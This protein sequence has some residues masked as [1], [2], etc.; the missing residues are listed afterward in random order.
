VI[1]GLLAVT[2]GAFVTV[3]M[4]QNRE[5]G[6]SGQL[7]ES[8]V[9]VVGDGVVLRSE[10][11]MRTD[12][13]IR[14]LLADQ[15]ELPPEQRSP[16][17]P[18][19]VI[20]DQVLDQLILKQI[21]MQRAERVGIVIGDDILNQALSQ[22]AAN[23]GVT[24]ENL[25][26][27]LEA[28]GLDY[29]IYRQDQRD[30]L[31]LSQLEQRDVLSRIE[32]SPRELEQ[33]LARREATETD[34]FDYNIS[35]ILIGISGS[36]QADELRAAQERVEE[37][38]ARLEAG[39][40][41]AQLAVEYSEGPTALEGGSLGWRKG[42]QLPTLFAD[43]VTE[44]QPGEISETIQSGSGFHIVRLNDMR[45]AER[46]MVDQVRARHIL[47]IPNEILDRDATLQKLI[48]IR[49]QILAGDDFGTLAI[50]QSEDTVSGSDGGDL[51]WAE[52][53]AYVPEFTEVLERLP[54]GELSEPVETRFGWHL[55]EVLDRRSYDSTDELKARSCQQQLQMSK[56]EEERLVW[57][58]QLRDGA[59]IEKKL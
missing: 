20:Q 44:M 24:L 41:F 45:G 47:L 8:I 7:I 58:Q 57:I 23:V 43:L 22:V 19:A 26:A 50:A 17:P 37:L 46:V 3:A 55:V 52:P 12:F 28:E 59:F 30:E 25:P 2:A 10:L 42:S 36:A 56:A 5:L 38:R 6:G 1:C 39:E 40:T 49:N 31:I 16:L 14:N 53:D 51:G 33:C 18:R 32:I 34:E 13:V 48:G 15:A 54:I 11:E 27:V 9:A 4:A 29:S 21:Q 35:H